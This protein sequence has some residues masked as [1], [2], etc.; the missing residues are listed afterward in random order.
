MLF[1][2]YVS[3]QTIICH[4]CNNRRCCNPSHLYAG[5]HQTNADDRARHGTSKKPPLH[6]GSQ[7]WNSVLTEKQVLEIKRRLEVGELPPR[8]AP[9]YG[10]SAAAIY[11]IRDGSNWAWL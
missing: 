11:K 9:V 8:I 1:N 2:G 5:T 10:V 7:Q 4:L 6:I 3:E